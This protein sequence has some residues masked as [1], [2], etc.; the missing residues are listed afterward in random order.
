MNDVTLLTAH[1]EM[2]VFHAPTFLP[3]L[4][5]APGSTSLLY[6]TVVNGMHCN[7]PLIISCTTQ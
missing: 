6:D 4:L 2:S 5:G 7:H 3:L 1:A